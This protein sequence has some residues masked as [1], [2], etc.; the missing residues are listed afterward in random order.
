MKNLVL[1]FK[2]LMLIVA[3]ILVTRCTHEDSVSSANAVD[4]ATVQLLDVAQTSG[5]LASGS[6]FRISGSSSDT[7]DDLSGNNHP[8]S[9]GPPSTT[10]GFG[11]RQSAGA[12]G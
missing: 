2:V 11:W 12:N 6:S 5:Q 1:A 7:T 4:E 8:R 3:V 10:G 9:H